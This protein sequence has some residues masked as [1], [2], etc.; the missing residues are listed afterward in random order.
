VEKTLLIDPRDNVIVA[1]Q[2]LAPGAPLIPGISAVEA[3]P[4]KHKAALTDLAPG[5]PVRM[6][7]VTVGKAVKPIRAGERISTENIV[8]EAESFGA[9]IPAAPWIAPDVSRWQGRTFQGYRRAN[10]SVGTA[11]H[12]IVLPMVFCENRNM[13]VIRDALRQIPGLT[14]RFGYERFVLDLIRRHREGESIEGA[15]AGPDAPAE[16]RLFPHVDGVKFLIHQ[17]GCGGTR[18]DARSLCALLAGYATHPNVAG[19]TVLSLGCQNAE[20]RMLEEEIAKRDAN[21]AKPLQ[22]LVQ[23]GYPSEEALISDAIR[24]IFRGLIT[25]NDCRREPLSLEHLCLGMEC[26]G[27]DGFSGISANPVLGQVSDFIVALGGKSVLAEFPELCGVEQELINRSIDDATGARFAQL[28]RQYE[29]WAAAVGASL[30]M[31]P[32]PGNI[33]DGL[34]T[35]AIKSAGAAKKGGT[36]P[37]VDV[38]DYTEPVRKPGL[39]LLNTPGNDAECTTALAGSG[40]NVI[41]FTTG[42]GTPMG[43]PV[44]PTLKIATNSE[45]ARRM[46]DIIDFDAGPVITGEAGIEGMGT[47]LLDLVIATASG[48]YVPKAVRL[49]QDDFIPWKRGVSL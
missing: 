37:V 43:N 16:E 12:W 27:S 42:L 47:Q 41:L 34:I 6:Y 21:F 24:H 39:N 3:V 44:A 10:G 49:G 46:G 20:V 22:V 4:A 48:E 33:A 1:L 17:M 32:S 2:N 5:Q 14:P 7:G 18:G 29:A 31:N 40:S 38:L 19:V 30:S 23:Q 35:D 15:S 8:H 11:N 28:M 25:I 9:R 45:L 36:S 26:G 13:E